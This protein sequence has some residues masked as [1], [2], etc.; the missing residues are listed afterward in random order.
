MEKW[1]QP[2]WA[3]Y[4]ATLGATLALVIY[5]N[6]RAVTAEQAAFQIA[7]GLVTGALGAFAGAAHVL[8]KQNTSGGPIINNPTPPA[9]PAEPQ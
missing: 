7:S 9:D 6:P 2:F 5:L 8:N 4:L 3:V 1:P